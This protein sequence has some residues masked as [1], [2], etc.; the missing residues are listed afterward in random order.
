MALQRPDGEHLA[1]ILGRQRVSLI[2]GKRVAET[3][4]LVVGHRLKETERERV[5]QDAVLLEVAPSADRRRIEPPLGVRFLDLEGSGGRNVG[6]LH[7][8]QG[9]E[10]CKK[11]GWQKFEVPTFSGQ[12]QCV[13]YFSSLRGGIGG[14]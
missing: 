2:D 4:H 6:T 11:G 14:R 5:G 8:S 1:A 12:D 3:L 9:A 7:P 10:D 13:S